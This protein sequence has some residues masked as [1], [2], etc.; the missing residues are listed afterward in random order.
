MSE[1]Y[2]PNEPDQGR[3]SLDK[4]YRKSGYSGGLA[5][6]DE[7]APELNIVVDDGPVF[8]SRC[9]NPIEPGDAFCSKCGAKTYGS[10]QD[11]ALQRQQAQQQQMQQP[12]PSQQ[13]YGGNVQSGIPM[14]VQGGV[15]GMPMDA[16]GNRTQGAQFGAAPVVNNYYYNSNN[17]INSGNYSS[18]VN[19]NGRVK[20]KYLALALCALFGWAGVHRFYEGKIATGILWLCTVGLFGF[21]YIIDLLILIF[22]KGRYYNP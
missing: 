13:G 6:Y 12:Y 20:D 1:F 4:P 8:C 16:Y 10:R 5:T 15:Q 21:G 18:N 17:N 14:N 3:V 7:P 19:M 22:K 9:G 11:D 2:N